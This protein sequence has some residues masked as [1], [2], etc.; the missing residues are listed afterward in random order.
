MADLKLRTDAVR[1]VIVPL[2][3]QHGDSMRAEFIKQET[4]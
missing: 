3:N 1:P 4:D 2:L